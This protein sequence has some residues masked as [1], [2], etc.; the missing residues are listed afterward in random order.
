[1]SI[2]DQLVAA[3]MSPGEAM[4]TEHFGSAVRLVLDRFSPETAS[5]ARTFWVPGRIEF[6]G[7]HTDYAGGRSLVC[8]I[9]RGIVVAARRRGDAVV[10]IRDVLRRQSA[11][12][13]LDVNAAS[14]RGHWSGYPA[15]VVRR[16]ARNFP[17]ARSGADIVFAS[18]L[19]MAS[20]MS[21]SSALIVA[22]FLALA[23]VNDLPSS[24][25][26]RAVIRG[27]EELAAYLGTVENGMS[28]GPLAGEA[29]V[30]TF[31]GS[32][33]HAAILCGTPGA[34]TQFSFSPVQE[35]RVIPLPAGYV[36]VVAC[37]GVL[38]EKTGAALGQYNRVSSLARD[39]LVGLRTTHGIDYATLAA[40]VAHEGAGTVL[41]DVPEP[42]RARVEQFMLESTVLV[43]QAGDALM[44][45]D[46][47]AV[48]ALVDRS[49]A[50][51][52]ALLGNQVSETIFLARSARDLGAVAAS[53]FGAG[54]GGSVWALVVGRNAEA[55]IA[56]WRE[57]Y[58]ANFP[59]RG[60]PRPGRAEFL[61]T[62]A[63]PHAC[64]LDAD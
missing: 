50:A 52:E 17:H 16:I 63:G 26:Y 33:D 6:L 38:A 56:Q 41:R 43:P 64:A 2:A 61:I 14:R 3:G 9:E 28:F 7:K 58:L 51:A 59:E 29:G 24:S 36:F 62:H 21:S 34:L 12:F 5:V 55:F 39:A 27:C 48:G 19:P 40:A 20:G 13:V 15:A 25:T 1:M 46:L 37:S 47:T 8:A 10:R 42:A 57:A 44:R 23:A 49:Q 22:T 35:E 31:G 54:F 45:G 32:E 53:A 4:R 11:E 18:D 30:G 60:R